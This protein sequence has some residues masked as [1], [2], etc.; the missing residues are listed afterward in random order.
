MDEAAARSG[1]RGE[2]PTAEAGDERDADAVG[3][4][5]GAKRFGPWKKLQQRSDLFESELE[6]LPAEAGGPRD[7]R[8]A[9]E[10]ILDAGGL[11]GDSGD[12]FDE[13]AKGHVARDDGRE[14]DGFGG[15][16]ADLHSDGVGGAHVMNLQWGS[17]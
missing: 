6:R 1:F 15:F 5:E 4:V 14:G 3:G 7:E 12:L 13:L 8:A 16:T 17:G 10:E 2:F 9:L 11:D